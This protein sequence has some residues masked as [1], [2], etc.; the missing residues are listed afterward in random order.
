MN[1]IEKIVLL[2]LPIIFIDLGYMLAGILINPMSTDFS[3]FLY[4]LIA[5]IE[6]IFF[7]YVWIRIKS[8]QL[9]LKE[10][11]RREEQ[12]KKQV[13]LYGM[14]FFLIINGMVLLIYLYYKN[15]YPMSFKF[16]LNIFNLLLMGFIVP[17]T[18]GICEETIWRGRIAW[19]L[20][21]EWNSKMKAALVSS[22]SFAFFHGFDPFKLA[23]TFVIGF[24]G[25]L[26]YLRI[27]NLYP[28][29]ASHIIA[30]IWSFIFSYIL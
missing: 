25:S 9:S 23:T 22:V 27:K 28:L 20:S 2:I 5:V 18:A 16:P 30:D 3:V 8:E 14:V 17:I 7:L 10:I 24:A 4:C 11:Y 21:N 13:I 6:W 29:I 19:E 12:P 1:K 26:I 15:L